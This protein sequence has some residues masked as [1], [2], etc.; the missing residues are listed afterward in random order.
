MSSE[1]QQQLKDETERSER[2]DQT[3]IVVDKVLRI[4]TTYNNFLD[5]LYRL[6]NPKSGIFLFYIKD[7]T[8]ELDTSLNEF[9]SVLITSI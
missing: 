4:M 7:T 9:K 2:V 6:S 1:V 8:K 5:D 3:I